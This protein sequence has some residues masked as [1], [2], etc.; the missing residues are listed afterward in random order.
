MIGSLPVAELALELHHCHGRLRVSRTYFFYIITYSYRHF[1]FTYVRL[2]RVLVL[3]TDVFTVPTKNLP[4]YDM[5]PSEG[6]L[7]SPTHALL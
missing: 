6:L 4:I 5:T 7:Q 1:R 3:N 2:F